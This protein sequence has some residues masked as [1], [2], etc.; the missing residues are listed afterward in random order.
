M[1]AAL[2]PVIA[3]GD[4]TPAKLCEQCGAVWKRLRLSKELKP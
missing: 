3:T 4:E 1:N 2:P